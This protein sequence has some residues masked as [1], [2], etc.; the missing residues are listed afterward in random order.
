MVLFPWSLFYFLL[1]PCSQKVNGHVPLF[2]EAPEGPPGGP[3]WGSL[4]TDM[5]LFTCFEGGRFRSRHAARGIEKKIPAQYY[6]NDWWELQFLILKFEMIT[7]KIDEFTANFK[8]DIK[9]SSHR[10]LQKIP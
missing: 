7:I 4:T 2:P 1:F 9:Y 10:P 8:S 6:L 3:P 5:C